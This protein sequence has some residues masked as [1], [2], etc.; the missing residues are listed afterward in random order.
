LNLRGGGL[1]LF[2]EFS[3]RSGPFLTTNSARASRMPPRLVSYGQLAELFPTRVAEAS[4]QRS[5]ASPCGYS[6]W[7]GGMGRW[8]AHDQV[9]FYYSVRFL[10]GF[11]PGS[12]FEGELNQEAIH[13]Q[14][15]RPAGSARRF[16]V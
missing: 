3:I 9:S 1:T 5:V 11:F 4:A 7:V 10:M 13:P 15:K 12:P 2:A 8:L 6:A 14:L 16:A